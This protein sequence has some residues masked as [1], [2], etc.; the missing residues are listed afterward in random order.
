MSYYNLRISYNY[1]VANKKEE[2]EVL[3]A[4]E[5]AGKGLEL[6]PYFEVKETSQQTKQQIDDDCSQRTPEQWLEA[7]PSLTKLEA[8]LTSYY[9]SVDNVDQS[10]IDYLNAHLDEIKNKYNDSAGDECAL[11]GVCFLEITESEDKNG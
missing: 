6:L 10:H 8:I 7:V 2:A 11:G 4:Y 5:E 9:W 1:T 3:S